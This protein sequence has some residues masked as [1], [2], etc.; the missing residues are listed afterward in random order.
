MKVSK[1]PSHKLVSCIKKREKNLRGVQCGVRLWA[2]TKHVRLQCL[3][4]W[5]RCSVC[6]L[7]SS[8]FVSSDIF[9]Y[10]LGLHIHSSTAQDPPPPPYVCGYAST[11]GGQSGGH[12][13]FLGDDLKS[14]QLCAYVRQRTYW[15]KQKCWW[16][17]FLFV[18][19]L[20][21]L[22]VFVS[23]SSSFCGRADLTLLHICMCVFFLT[24]LF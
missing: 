17:L 8:P 13:L 4:S 19:F 16:L 23:L 9:R 15:E 7:H 22:Q 20:V 11:P 5:N 18:C 14:E 3:A 24:Y 1:K 21:H 2:S 6:F 10:R 12:V